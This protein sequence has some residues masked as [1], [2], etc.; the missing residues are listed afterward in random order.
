[1]NMNMNINTYTHSKMIGNEHRS[2]GVLWIWLFFI[3]LAAVQYV[4]QMVDH[5]H[6]QALIFGYRLQ[7][8][9]NE[10]V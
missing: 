5:I 8:F 7:R 10:A 6:G 9:N 4:E 2:F 3:G 1:M